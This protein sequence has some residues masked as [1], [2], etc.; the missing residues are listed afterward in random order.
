VYKL[1]IEIVVLI[2]DRDSGKSTTLDGLFSQKYKKIPC[3]NV[4]R[5]S[6]CTCG[7]KKSVQEEVEFC[8]FE[9]VIEKIKSRIQKCMQRRGNN[10]TIV[11]PFTIEIGGRKSGTKG[12]INRECIIEPLK[13]LKDNYKTYIVYL[14][15][16]KR[17]A[18]IPLI[19][20]LM[21]EIGFDLKIESRNAP[22]EQAKE[23]ITF[24]ERL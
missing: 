17:Q 3:L 19:D 7:G 24:I 15:G 20:T 6:V 21:K 5:K 18:D 14:R 16:G 4:G 11:I 2:G 10:I 12:K 23:L 9:K 22:Q 13:W 1:P 8:N